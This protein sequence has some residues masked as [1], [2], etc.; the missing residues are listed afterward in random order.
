MTLET[1]IA[2]N[3]QNVELM[4]LK[5]VFSHTVLASGTI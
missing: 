3:H 2:S 4:P 1:P 5:T